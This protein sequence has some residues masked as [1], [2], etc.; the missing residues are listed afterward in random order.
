MNILLLVSAFLLGSIIASF[1][2][3]VAER[4]HTGEPWV[5]GRSRCNSCSRHL[6]ARDLVPVFSWLLSGGRCRK[7]SAKVPGSYALL[8]ASTGAAFVLAVHMNGITPELLPFLASLSVLVFIVAYDIRH[9]IVPWTASLLLIAFSL[10]HA[11]LVSPSVSSLGGTLL[12]AGLIGGGFFLAHALSRGRAM[13]LADAPISFALSLL[14]APYAFTGLL[15][16]F[17]IGAVWGIGVLAL[18][19]GG[20]RMGIEVP[21]APF[22]ALG[23]LLAYFVQWN[24]L[25]F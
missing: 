1:A 10:A 9:T 22:L 17:W 18:R 4:L 12:T 24:P 6:T 16:S 13:G 20:P 2:T 5:S 15:F 3:V 25:A 19:R 7:C 14:V 21:F 23:Y 8:E 11:L